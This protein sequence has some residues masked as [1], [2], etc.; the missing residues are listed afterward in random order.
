M[1]LASSRIPTTA[2]RFLGTSVGK[3]FGRFVP[4]ALASFAVSE[5][6]L[7]LCVGPAH[8]TAGISAVVAWFAGAAV[9]YVLSRWAWERTGRP[10]LLKE[11]L[12]FWV[13]SVAVVFILT[14]SSKWANQQA[15]S[16][17]LSHVDRVLFVATAYFVANCVTFLSRF[18]IF[19]FFLFAD[20]DARI[21]RVS[22]ARATRQA[23]EASQSAAASEAAAAPADPAP[24]DPASAPASG[25]R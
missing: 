11:T 23:A 7:V 20:R 15:L 17:N 2:R 5:I 1:T 6:T 12:P 4:V 22:K 3:R 13:I 9:S 25:S 19:H 24:A 21:P 18:L 16:M 14:L 10:H 8:M